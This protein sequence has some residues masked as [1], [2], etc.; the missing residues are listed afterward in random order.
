M[1]YEEESIKFIQCAYDLL[2]EYDRQP[3]HNNGYMGYFLGKDLS[4]GYSLKITNKRKLALC[5]LQYD[6]SNHTK[7][8]IVLSHTYNDRYSQEVYIGMLLGIYIQKLQEDLNNGG[9][10][11]KNS[12]TSSSKKSLS[13]SS[14]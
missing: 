6:S 1:N 4:Y 8:L 11:A 12:K 7:H 9:N 2:H 13:S 3:H 5:K 14:E 10:N